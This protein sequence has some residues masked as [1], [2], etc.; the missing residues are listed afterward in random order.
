M[1]WGDENQ[2]YLQLPDFLQLM[3]KTYLFCVSFL[4]LNICSQNQDI[5]LSLYIRVPLM[6]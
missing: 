1:L 2:S 6:V 5:N 4:F 3:E